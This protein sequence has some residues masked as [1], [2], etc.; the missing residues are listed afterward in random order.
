MLINENILSFMKLCLL[1]LCLYTLWGVDCM[2]TEAVPLPVPLFTDKV[3]NYSI[4][5][6]KW[7]L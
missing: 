1:L 6:N 4:H 3:T 2:L 5:N 7:D